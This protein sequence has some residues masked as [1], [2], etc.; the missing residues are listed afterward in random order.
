MK[1]A[2]LLFICFP[3]C[4][5]SQTSPAN[6][7]VA[8]MSMCHLLA[9]YPDN[10]VI[11]GKL[12]QEVDQG[13]QVEVLEVYR[14]YVPETVITIWDGAPI[15]YY[16]KHARDLFAPDAE[17]AVMILFPIDSIINPWDQL[18]DYGIR[19]MNWCAA[20]MIR[21]GDLLKGGFRLPSANDL[22]VGEFPLKDFVKEAKGCIKTGWG[23]T[24]IFPNPAKDIIHIDGVG[25]IDQIKLWNILGQDVLGIHKPEFPVELSVSHLASGVYILTLHREGSF[26]AKEKVRIITGR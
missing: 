19:C 9:E 4:L 8:G 25:Q 22:G 26:V 21:E 11:R 2:L 6:D 3:I 7:F 10:P 5:F 16:T 23:P 12:I 18:G 14:G 24:G 13:I 20:H 1:H 15:R 17:E